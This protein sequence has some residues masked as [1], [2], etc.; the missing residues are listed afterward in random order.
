MTWLP[1]AL[2]ILGWLLVPLLRIQKSKWPEDPTDMTKQSCFFNVLHG[3]QSTFPPSPSPILKGGIGHEKA[4]GDSYDLHKICC[5]IVAYFLFLKLPLLQNVYL[6]KNLFESFMA[7]NTSS[8][9]IENIYARSMAESFVRIFQVNIFFHQVIQFEGRNDQT[10]ILHF[11]HKC[12][13]YLRFFEI[14]DRHFFLH[15]EWRFFRDFWIEF[16]I[17]Q[18]FFAKIKT[19]SPQLVLKL[20]DFLLNSQHRL[21]R[22]IQ[23]WSREFN[24]GL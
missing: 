10:S 11:L 24:F 12:L 19:K 3:S 14:D 4:I 22:E 13:T 23:F 16:C 6:W 1:C 20:D 17:K 8:A 21:I 2:R 9:S 5:W 7:S 18:V 15:A